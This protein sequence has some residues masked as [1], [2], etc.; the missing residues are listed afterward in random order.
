MHYVNGQTRLFKDSKSSQKRFPKIIYHIKSCPAY[1]QK[2]YYE[3]AVGLFLKALEIGPG[4]KR[5]YDNI[6]NTYIDRE[7]YD[8]AISAHNKFINVNSDDV[9]AFVSIGVALGGSLKRI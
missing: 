7:I 6:G 3:K 5:T 8:D 9:D 1:Y 4:D 2:G